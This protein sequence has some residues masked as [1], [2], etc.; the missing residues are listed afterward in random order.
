[1]ATFAITP[2]S[3]AAI[4]PGAPWAWGSNTYGQLGDNTT[5]DKLTPVAVSGLTG[6]TAIAGGQNFSL[7]LKSD[8]TAWAWGSNV[9]GQL[10]DNTTVDKH[11]PLAVSGLTGVTAIAA[12][13]NHSLA[14]KSDGTVW[15]W[16]WNFA[17][18]L[19]DGS[20]GD[21]HTP[22]PVSGLNGVTGIAAG[23]AHRVALKSDGTVWAW[24]EN[25]AHTPAQV[26]GLTGVAAIAAGYRHSLALK[27]DGS[28]WAWGSNSSGQLGD[29]T[30]V[31][32]FTPVA[33][34]GL[35]G[36]TALAGGNLHSLALKSDGSVWAWGANAY[37][38]LGDG[39]TA[40][41]HTPVAVNGLTGVTAVAAGSLHSLGLKSDGTVWAWGA[42]FS[43]QL[44]DSTT[45]DKQ[46][47]VAVS[48]LTGVTAIAAG[49][50]FSLALRGG[51]PPPPPPPPSP[52]ITA[53]SPASA[54]AGGHDL[55]L[56]ISGNNFDLGAS[57]QWNGTPLQRL[58]LAGCGST[59]CQLAVS[60]PASLITSFGA[61]EITVASGTTMS[62]PATF[63]VTAT[64]VGVVASASATAT[65]AHKVAQA[66]A[67]GVTAVGQG[68]G[69]LSV[70]LFAGNP[71][72]TSPSPS[73]I[74]T[75][76]ADIRAASGS[77][78]TSITVTHCATGG[79]NQMSYYTGGWYPVSPQTVSAGTAC[80]SSVIG[81]SSSPKVSQMSGTVFA[82]STVVQPKALLVGC[83][84][85]HVAVGQA[86]R[87]IGV[88]IGGGSGAATPSGVVSFASS[89]AG[90]F[91]G[92]PCT[93]VGFGP[94]AGCQ[95]TYTPS[96]VGTGSHAITA[97]YGGDLVYAPASATHALTVATADD[98]TSI[99]HDDAKRV[100]RPTWGA[101][102]A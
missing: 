60:V 84:P 64:G 54:Q 61:A 78:F 36:V 50:Y 102:G 65:S 42:N 66:S 73:A 92:S 53:L 85:G 83:A 76:F 51:T 67:G 30:T 99:G 77:S 1:M 63:Y 98:T 93:L 22:L 80:I 9:Y 23:G 35:T 27:S 52:A 14:L 94:L 91:A 95:V 71:V 8:G 97:D 62:P 40:E 4:S 100:P 2:G 82:V 72:A 69:T 86:T 13:Q 46:S 87:C 75:A 5:V 59:T 32:T 3:A 70:G 28:V 43:G 96:A 101:P 68:I 26:S 88:V 29:G 56:T 89:G 44:G 19:G 57:A 81:S 37:G 45:V 58:A 39:T 21:S 48:G 6:V 11:T 12:G 31:G 10:G 90:T 41:K 55:S 15:A 49:E 79:G 7:A 24:G 33:V 74:G 47:P 25:A 38:E 20:V 34:S 16:G 18:Q 17:G